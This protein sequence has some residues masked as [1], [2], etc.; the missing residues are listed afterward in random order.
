MLLRRSSIM[1]GVKY[2]VMHDSRSMALLFAVMLILLGLI[3]V[4]QSYTD[5]RRVENREGN[6]LRSSAA[7][8]A[9]AVGIELTVVDKALQMLRGNL[10]PDKGSVFEHVELDYLMVTLAQ[11]MQG[12]RT[13]LLLDANGRAI[14]SN[15]PELRGRDF[16][17]REYFKRVKAN[18]DPGKL[19]IS[20]PFETVLG[21]YS[22]NV[23]RAVITPGGNFAGAFIATLDPGYISVLLRAALTAPDTRVRLVHDSGSLFQMEPA[24]KGHAAK[25]D[26]DRSGSL[27]RRHLDG[28]TTLS[29]LSGLD[30]STGTERL[31]AQHTVQLAGVPMDGH[32]VTGVSREREAIFASWRQRTIGYGLMYLLLVTLSVVGWRYLI[33]REDERRQALA[34]REAERRVDAERLALALDGGDLGLWDWHIP[35]GRVVYD[36]R[37]CSMLGYGV[38]EIAPHIDSWR[39]L[40]HPEDWPGVSAKL[41]PHLRGETP[42]YRV[43]MRLRHRD[44]RWIWVLDAG[45]VTERDV[46][47]VALRAVGTHLDITERKKAE[48]SIAKLTRQYAVLG[49]ISE[50]IV[51]ARDSEVMLREA[52]RIAAEDGEL[53]LVWLGRVAPDSQDV[54]VV[55]AAGI[56]QGFAQGLKESL[57]SALPE[58]RGPFAVALRERRSVVVEDYQQSMMTAP[59]RRRAIVWNL[60]SV[61]VCPIIRNGEVWGGISFYS[62]Q[63]G[64]FESD[65][66][67]LIEEL[68]ANV[69]FC[70]DTL[71]AD[72]QRR[73]LERSLRLLSR[74]VEASC[75]GVYIT[76][77]DNRFTMVNPAFCE[78]TGYTADELIGAEPSILKSGRQDGTF[79]QEMWSQLQRDGHWQGEIWDRRKNGEIFPALLSITELHDEQ[80]RL[81]H[82][83]AFFSDISAQKAVQQRVE[84]LAHHDLLTDLPNRYLLNDRVASAVGRAARR[85]GHIALLYLDLDRFKYVNDALGHDIGDHLLRAVAKRIFSC[86]RG[87]DT[88]CRVGGDEFVVLLDDVVAGE[89]A[90]RVAEKIMAAV[91]APYEIAG[92]TMVVGVSVGIA[93]YPDNG[94]TPDEL[95]RGAD[96]ALINVK[97]SGRGNFGF[98]S[99]QLG[100]RAVERLHMENDL[101]G[102]CERGEIF[103]VYQPQFDIAT[104]KVVGV[105]ALARWRHPVKGVVSPSHFIPVAEDSG[106][107]LDIGVF[108]LRE[109]CLQ[110]SEWRRHGLLDV[111][112]AVNVSAVQFRQAD[113]VERLQ[114]IIAET[115]LPPRL[116]ELE[117]TESVVMENVDSVLEKFSGIHAL[118]ISLALDDFGTGYSSLSYLR[119]IPAQKLKIDQSFVR[120][121]P[122][123]ADAA[124]IA[125]TIVGMAHALELH[126]LAEGVERQ[127]Q[128]DFLRGIGCGRG[129]G[130]LFARPMDVVAFERW[131]VERNAKEASI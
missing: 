108:V 120:D 14:A 17:E 59:W 51:R 129:Q 119:R 68:T 63:A 20:Q 16:S 31:M 130:Y 80:G 5:Y 64:F 41:E 39:G 26:L 69:G 34:E 18:P 65:Q 98:Y 2:P 55:A 9:E 21:V 78:L 56:A 90:A 48:A 43:E 67:R 42:A 62:G 85:K 6:L 66:I 102:A 35:S 8:I 96:A 4:H 116:L 75:D 101:R 28:N 94:T 97:Q 103:L 60:V 83:I 70:L 131:L 12:V 61:V 50:M 91:S 112:V 58:G 74:L 52:C 29:L 79:Y 13:F 121:L 125:R 128:A 25:K 100:D 105:E 15:R 45:K 1:Q 93:V 110:M 88:V 89:D 23:T 114:R 3:G 53:P 86:V 32:L 40:V 54:K 127:D 77:A 81:D 57:D 126:V 47:G 30:Y 36:T 82:R 122:A 92:H 10:V 95:L 73:D 111:S 84:H 76:D 7:V 115:G 123:N 22:L 11:S 49:R 117:V 44:G 33:L 107:I 19:F 71:D 72:Q 104:G 113:L 106:L 87:S 109:A 38:D 27:L 99:Q 37:W 124:A 24:T 46:N 118:G